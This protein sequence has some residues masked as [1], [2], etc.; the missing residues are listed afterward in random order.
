MGLFIVIKS[1]FIT[2]TDTHVGKTFAS[3]A[4]LQAA[5]QQ[6]HLTAGY[7]PVA[8][9]SQMTPEG[10]RNQD[11]IFLQ[12]YSTQK[13]TYEQV[14]PI[15][16]LEA[17]AP[18]IASR[19]ERKKITLSDLSQGLR[20][21]ERSA[22]WICIEGAGGWFTPLSDSITFADWVQKEKL[23]VIM[24]VALKLG[25]LNHA[26]LTDQAIRQANLPL[27]G[28]IANTLSPAMDRQEEYLS[29]LEKRLA[30]PLLG[31]IPYLPIDLKDTKKNH[32]ADYLNICLLNE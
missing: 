1:W 3:C 10:L 23:K 4:L 24:V 2:G 20:Q 11:A 22:D 15:T 30:S 16:F 14:N 26:L 19:S 25:C 9:G 8:S 5:A 6:G 17:T 18:H 7:K 21:L 32:L 12:A 27:A 31:V 29:S 13:F 28:W